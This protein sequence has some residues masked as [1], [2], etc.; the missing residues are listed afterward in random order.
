[1]QVIL[2]EISD[3]HSHLHAHTE[4]FKTYK[5]LGNI[6]FH[7]QQSAVMEKPCE[8]KVRKVGALFLKSPIPL[9]RLHL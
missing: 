1:M 6:D 7:P 4:T 5:E 3:L 2:K 8:I 9:A